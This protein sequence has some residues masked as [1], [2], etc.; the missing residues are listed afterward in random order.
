MP[1]ISI[2]AVRCSRSDF[3]LQ[4]ETPCYF[5]ADQPMKIPGQALGIPQRLSAEQTLPSGPSVRAHVKT[6]LKCSSVLSFAIRSNGHIWIEVQATLPCN[7]IAMTRV[8]SHALHH[9]LMKNAIPSASSLFPGSARKTQRQSYRGWVARTL[10]AK[11]VTRTGC[12]FRRSESITHL[13]QTVMHK[14]DAGCAVAVIGH[15]RIGRILVRRN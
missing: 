6:Y 9:C 14:E 7:Y 15:P 11:C 3:N 12:P 8:T 5:Y 1:C 10:R 4:K 2:N 13:L